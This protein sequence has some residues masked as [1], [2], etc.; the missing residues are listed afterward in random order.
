MALSHP[1][2]VVLKSTTTLTLSER[3]TEMMRNKSP[4][5][6]RNPREEMNSNAR[7]SAKNRR[8]AEQ[9]SR[10]SGGK[11]MMDTINKESVKNRIDRSQV[12]L[13][14]RDRLGSPGRRGGNVQIRLGRGRGGTM[15]GGRGRGSSRG[16]NR[17]GQNFRSP[18]SNRGNFGTR[19]SFRGSNTNRSRG[20][21]GGGG[22]QRGSRGGGQR[23]S[24]GGGQR[25]RGR[26]G[27]E[28]R[29]V[30]QT[31]LDKELETYMSGAK[32]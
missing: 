18:R 8:L 25:G 15:R 22:G 21:R 3:F 30:D 27:R 23:G 4:A 2:K 17:G 29:P 26:G 20:A 6:K 12:K 32:T 10:R 13:N 16:I 28:R 14:V 31:N 19:D 5:K 7:A 9:M 24:R 11:A 1:V